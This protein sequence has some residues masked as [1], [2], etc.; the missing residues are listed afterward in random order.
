M[1]CTLQVGGGPRPNFD[2]LHTLY[3]KGQYFTYIHEHTSSATSTL[4][5]NENTN[6]KKATSC[7]VFGPPYNT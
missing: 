4:V 3:L 5:E 7:R 1:P 6:D 2:A